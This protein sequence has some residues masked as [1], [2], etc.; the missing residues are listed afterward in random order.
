MCTAVSVS[1]LP[2]RSPSSLHS[3]QRLAKHV[4]QVHLNALQQSEEAVEGEL[5]LLTLK[6]FIAYCRRYGAHCRSIA[7]CESSHPLL[8]PAA[9]VA[10]GSPSR[11]L[12]SCAIAMS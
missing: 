1:S 6:R 3:P 9:S 2:S 12:R 5:D 11:Q 7:V 10:L 4:M 8:L